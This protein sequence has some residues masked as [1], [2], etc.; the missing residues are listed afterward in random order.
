[1]SARKLQHLVI[2]LLV[3]E[4]TDWVVLVHTHE[5]LRRRLADKQECNNGERSPE[6]APR[7][8]N[9]KH[10][11]IMPAYDASARIDKVWYVLAILAFLPSVDRVDAVQYDERAGRHT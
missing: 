9:L 4:R 6:H 8:L 2:Q 3:A 1:M 7:D 11:Q 10:M 5:T